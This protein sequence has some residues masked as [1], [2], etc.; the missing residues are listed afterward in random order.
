MEERATIQASLKCCDVRTLIK[1]RIICMKD[2]KFTWNF[3]FDTI[4]CFLTINTL[5]FQK[6]VILTLYFP[7]CLND[8]HLTNQPSCQLTWHGD[9]LVFD[10][11]ALIFDDE[12]TFFWCIHFL[13][14]K[15]EKLNKI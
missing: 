2:I 8:D 11:L 14:I 3:Y 9:V 4:L 7:V 12:V 1:T 10:E 6:R 13:G 15:I 5:S